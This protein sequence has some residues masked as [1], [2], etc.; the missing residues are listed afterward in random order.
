MTDFSETYEILVNVPSNAGSLTEPFLFY[1]SPGVHNDSLNF[2]LQYGKKS[3]Q[4]LMSVREASSRAV[5]LQ[6]IHAR[7]KSA[8]C[9]GTVKIVV[10]DPKMLKS[11][12]KEN[13][14]KPRTIFKL[15]HEFPDIFQTSKYGTVTAIKPHTCSPAPKLF[16]IR[17]E[18]R[19]TNGK[20]SVSLNNY[21]ISFHFKIQNL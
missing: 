16:G 18:F 6:C 17:R 7:S 9:T 12:R 5:I 4:F 19:H 1:I 11:E 21:I 8:K 15:D 14:K 20:L 2:Y 3:Q 13:L 10:L